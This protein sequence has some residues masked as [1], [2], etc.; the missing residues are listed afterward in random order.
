MDEIKSFSNDL[1]ASIFQKQQECNA[2]MIR[3]CDRIVFNLFNESQ[4]ARM[5]QHVAS[6]FLKPFVLA[7]FMDIPDYFRFLFPHGGNAFYYRI[8]IDNGEKSKGTFDCGLTSEEYD[9]NR[10]IIRCLMYAGD[11]HHDRRNPWLAMLAERIK[12]MGFSFD[13]LVYPAGI[14][15]GES[16]VL[17]N[18]SIPHFPLPG[19]FSSDRVRIRNREAFATYLKSNPATPVLILTLNL[20]HMD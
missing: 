19:N 14:A 3:E 5:A 1:R 2:L 10:E 16:S 17:S 18:D 13:Y 8:E 12:E 11:D 7:S 6:N 20:A 9:R 4:R 15:E